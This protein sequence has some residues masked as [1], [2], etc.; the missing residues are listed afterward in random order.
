MP[1]EELYNTKTIIQTH[2]ADAEFVKY[3]ISLFLEHIPKTNADLKKASDAKDWEAVYFSAHKIKA[4][5]DLFNLGP[6]KDLI[7]KVE[8]KVKNKTET[9]TV[10]DDVNFISDYINKSIA[11]MKK[12]FNL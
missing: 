8:Y 9:D 1:E 12:D 11:A 7:R 6:L 2:H 4:S 5:I 3:M 10:A